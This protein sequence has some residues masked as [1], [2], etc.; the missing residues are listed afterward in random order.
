VN[1]EDVAAESPEKIMKIPI[2]IT[3][4]MTPELALS[5]AKKLG[6]AERSEEASQIFLNC[7]KL[8]TQKDA[9]MVEINPLAEDTSGQ[10]MCLDAKLKFDDNAEFRQKNIFSLRDWTQEDDK[11]V[12]ASKYNLNYI[13]L[14][15]NI[16]KG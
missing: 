9:L 8:F 3:V 5:V 10:F 15:G 14:D 16:G 2:D 4:G 12:E 1:I 11:E 7:Y 13:A 6:F